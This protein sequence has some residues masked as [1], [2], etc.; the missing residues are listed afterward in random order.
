MMTDT[1]FDYDPGAALDKGKVHGCPGLGCHICASEAQ[2]QASRKIAQAV[3]H[4]DSSWLD[5]AEAVIR[6]NA[7]LGIDFT[8]DEVMEE[9]QRSPF[10]THE[11][12]ALGGVVR[13]L[14]REG[15]MVQ[16]GFTKSRRRHSTPI[17]VYCGAKR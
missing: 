9:M 6:H 8:T 15:V 3:Q 12:R 16:V 10:I 14:I 4:A 7:R 5:H 17:P 2:A 11:P 13:R 1:L